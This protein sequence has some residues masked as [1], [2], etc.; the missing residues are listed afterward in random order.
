MPQLRPPTIPAFGTLFCLNPLH[1][2]C[3]LHSKGSS[4]GLKK[5]PA[6]LRWPCSTLAGSL[7]QTSKKSRY[8]QKR[9]SHPK[10]LTHEFRHGVVQ[11]PESSCHG[12]AYALSDCANLNDRYEAVQKP[13]YVSAMM[14]WYCHTQ[15]DGC[16]TTIHF[17]LSTM[18]SNP[19]DPQ[20][21]TA[22]ELLTYLQPPSGYAYSNLLNLLFGAKHIA[23]GCKH[24][25]YFHSTLLTKSVIFCEVRIPPCELATTPS[26]L[27]FYIRLYFNGDASERQLLNDKNKTDPGNLGKSLA[28]VYQSADQLTEEQ[29]AEFKEAFS[30]FDKDGDGTITTKE[31]GTVMRSLGQNP[32]E[33]ELQDMINEVDADGNGTIDFPE[34]LTMMARKMKDTDSEEEIREAFR[35]FDKDGNGFISAAELR[36]VM[37]NLGEK[38]TDEEV[39]EMIREADIDGDGQVNYEENP[40]SISMIPVLGECLQLQIAIV[41]DLY[42][43]ALAEN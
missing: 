27:T 15:S 38:L 42:A 11:K 26:P 1:L 13:K 33:A 23:L 21:A 36:H 2:I 28:P 24:L 14:A 43:T 30:L 37:T 32:T 10:H 6:N 5:I 39:D 4:S 3:A 7:D 40:G 29:I 41:S 35:V 17:L 22:S 20:T 9:T 25:V 18:P 31:L 16:P 12:N 34:F 8:P 19:L